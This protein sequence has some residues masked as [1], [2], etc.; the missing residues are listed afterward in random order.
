MISTRYNNQPIV[1]GQ[2]VQLK[3]GANSITLSQQNG[4]PLN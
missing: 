4:T 1:W 3:P 2:P